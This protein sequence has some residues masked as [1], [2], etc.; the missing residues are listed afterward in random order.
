MANNNEN[1][2]DMGQG[3]QQMGGQGDAGKVEQPKGAP[4]AANRDK[5]VGGKSPPD[6]GTVGN[7]Q[8]DIDVG[9]EKTATRAPQPGTGKPIQKT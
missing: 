1:K 7:D 9:N 8:L 5:N 3:R 6:Q 2:N 4:T